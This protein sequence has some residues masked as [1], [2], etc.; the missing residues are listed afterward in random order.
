MAIKTK[1]NKKK[2]I[3]IYAVEIKMWKSAFLK[4]HYKKDG[5]LN[6]HWNIYKIKIIW[7]VHKKSWSASPN[8][9]VFSLDLKY[10]QSLEPLSH[11]EDCFKE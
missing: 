10:Q 4:L 1:I 3:K 5:I 8:N 9:W 6:Y 11:W 7:K 2:K